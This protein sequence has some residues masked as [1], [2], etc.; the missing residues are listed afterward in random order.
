M[1]KSLLPKNQKVNLRIDDIRLG[2]NLGTSKIIRFTEKSFFYTK[3]GFT[4]S[5]SGLLKNR[6]AGYIH[7]IEGTYKNE[8]QTNVTGIHEILSKCDCIDG[9][10]AN[11]NREPILYSF[12]WDEPPVHKIYKKPRI[13]LCKKIS[14]SVLS[15]IS[16]YLED[17][18]H[19]P[20]DFDRET[21]LFTCQLV[22]IIFLFLNGLRL[23]ST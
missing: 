2:S 3:L 18:D 21:I 6:P 15:H 13:E 12:A 10:F 1:S 22:K 7:K 20:V 23:N 17:D 19:K 11:G 14:N 5:N 4:Q 8:K 16:L 9:S